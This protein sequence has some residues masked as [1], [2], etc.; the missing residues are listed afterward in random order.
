MSAPDLPPLTWL[1]AFEAAARHL[2]FTLAAKELNLTQ[3][4]VSQHVRSLEG[5]LGQLLFVRRV[6]ALSL[7]E[8]GA[9]YLPVVREAFDVLAT[10]TRA[11]GAGDRGR[12]LRLNCNIT[13]GAWWL[14]PR[15]GRLRK[16]APWLNLRVQTA[17]WG[18]AQEP[19]NSDI[20][21]RFGRSED[22][23]AEAE[24]ILRESVAPVCTPE[25]AQG[26]PDWRRD[27]LMDCAGM[28]SGW[29]KWLEM[30]GETL[31][32]TQRVD[33]FSTYM[34]SVTA[35]ANGQ[36]LAMAQKFMADTLASM[37][38]LI[39]PWPYRMPLTEAYFLIPPAAH[40]RTPATRAFQSWVEDEMG[41]G[42]SA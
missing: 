41:R 35:A 21:L 30:Q 9:N 32:D 38:N 20:D 29:H 37:G 2:S 19:G 25:F 27:P 26:S 28:I 14:A 22:M 15:L 3:S 33:L 5:W 24:L 6:R 39:E 12:V 8:A 11:F 31:P 1:R 18:G 36:G 34:I 10:G 17:T 16:A 7:T 40:A 42:M 23:S 4:A 13:F